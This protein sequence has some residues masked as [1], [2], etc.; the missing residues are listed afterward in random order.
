MSLLQV[1]GGASTEQLTRRAVLTGALQ[2]T[3]GA[4][5]A[6]GLAGFPALNLRAQSGFNAGDASQEAQGFWERPRWVWLKRSVTG[7]QI[8]V[9][10]WQD[11]QLIPEA[12]QQLC[13]FLRDVRFERMLAANDPVIRHALNRGQIGEQ[14]LSPWL[15]MDPVLLDILYAF[16]AWLAMFNIN[17]PI[18]LTSA[19]RHLVTNL[20]TE[21]AARDSWHVQGGAADIVVQGVSPA[22]LA[23]FGLWLSGGGVGI[24]QSRGFIH[25]DRGRLRTWRG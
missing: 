25:L 16:S 4:V 8:R 11:G 23:K 17:T 3:A 21:G 22:A 18:L 24:Y 19:F 6:S 15:L 1:V 9:V 14:H 5:L 2:R 13:W 7:G 10:Y 20:M 12:Y